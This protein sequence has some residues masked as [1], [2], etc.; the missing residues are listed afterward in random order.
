MMRYLDKFFKKPN[1]N[2][3]I[4]IG[5]FLSYIIVG[6][7]VYLWQNSIVDISK[8]NE[9]NIITQTLNQQKKNVEE[10]ATLQKNIQ[11]QIEKIKNN[12]IDFNLVKAGDRLPNGMTAGN[13]FQQGENKFIEF[14]GSIVI[15]GNFFSNETIK[16]KICLNLNEESS[17]KVPKIS[18]A[19][20]PLCF[21]NTEIA[22]IRFGALGSKGSAEVVIDN[23]RLRIGDTV[24]FDEA[25][26]IKTLEINK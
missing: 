8:K 7:G 14:T 20:K 24:P 21:T 3:V 19:T 12:Q 11:S 15:S 4:W 2:W 22:K 23:F 6:L 17:I 10:T 5:V 9:K 16:G 1:T 18:E 26:L 25:E 13:I